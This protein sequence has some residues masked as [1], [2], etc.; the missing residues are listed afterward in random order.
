MNLDPESCY[1]ALRT[2]D[3]R[4]D[5]R[6][7]TGITSTG[8]YCRPVCPART[9]KRDNC[10]FFP[11]ATSAEEAGFRPCL[12]CRPETSPGTPAWQGASATVS[13]AL[14]LI[15]DG[16]LDHG[17][18]DDLAERLGIGARHLRRLFDEHIGAGPLAVA[19]TRR[20]HFAKRLLEETD[21]SILQVAHTTGF[22]NA[23]RFN[24]AF[25]NR[26]DRPPSVVRR[27]ATHASNG[28]AISLRM[29]FRPP[30]AWGTL[31]R[32]LSPR[33]IPGVEEVLGESYRRTIV[34]AGLEGVLEVHPDSAGKNLVLEVP[35]AAAP[36]LLEIVERVRRF[37]D[38]T[39]D[40]EVIE[41]QLNND[42]VLAALSVPRGLRV[43]GAWDNFE[44]AIRTI[45]GQQVTVKSATTLSGRLVQAFG[46]KFDE[47][48][49][50]C[51]I[52][53]TPEKV[54][55]ASTKK[56]AAIGMPEAR[57]AAIQGL[58]RAVAEGRPVLEP[59][60]DLEEA[61]SRLTA[62]AGIGEWSANYIA[63]RAL[64]EP[65][66]FPSGDLGLRRALAADA[67]PMTATAL[68]RQAEVWRPWRAYAA[69]RLWTA[70]T[71]RLEKR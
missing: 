32:Y 20:V 3:Q 54:A 7:F 37:L 35:V 67:R 71:L 14:R 22:N 31:L 6:F 61:V 28:G 21:L 41:E 34:L 24:A 42:P 11:H 59:A 60:A 25:R 26:F 30:L 39:A 13:R 58:A 49:N 4:F 2:R 64:R 29:S 46:R 43:P 19:M 16:A 63:M 23:R 51:W 53:P 70:L 17:G 66:A 50:L 57:A 69:I 62:L 12:R 65:D 5:G 8:V 55:D 18:V 44:L 47:P 33:L 40:P 68:A 38:L 15:D 10:R 1:R 48:G 27:A 45:L 56:I 36:H 52:F 9:P